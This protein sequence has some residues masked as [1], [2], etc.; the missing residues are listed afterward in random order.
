MKQ[1]IFSVVL[2]VSLV[3]PFAVGAQGG[4]GA[5]GTV[6][7]PGD[8]L[9]VIRE[10]LNEELKSLRA[11]TTMDIKEQREDFQA[12]MDAL[13]MQFKSTVEAARAAAKKRLETARAAAK[14]AIEAIKDEREKEVVKRLDMNFTSTSLRMAD[15]YS[16]NLD[17]L[18]KVLARVITRTNTAETQG[19]AVAPVRTAIA[20]AST[21]IAAARA[22]IVVQSG[23]TYAVVFNSSSTIKMDIAAIRDTLKTDL[24]V[25]ET[26]VKTARDMV[27]TAAVTLAQVHGIEQTEHATSTLPIAT[28]TATSTQ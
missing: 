6:A 10:N 26:A 20:S 25:V 8:A 17:Q 3:I 14:K 23:K 13:R 1:K 16:D 2:A 28:S 7:R 19:L 18:D 22:A 27:H 15:R 9:R 11:S 5:T 12:K 21:S 24:K 4:N